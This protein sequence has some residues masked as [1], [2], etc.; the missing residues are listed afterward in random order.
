MTY[1]VPVGKSRHFL[2]HANRLIDAVLGGYNFYWTYTIASGVPA[3]MSISGQSLPTYTAGT[4]TFTNINVPQY[5]SFMPNFGGLILLKRPSLRDN[6]QDLGGDRFNH[7]NQNSMIN[8]GAA[9]VNWGNDCFTYT[10]PFSLGNNGANLWNNQRI[11][12]AS[13]ALAKEVPLKGEPVPSGPPPG[14]P[15]PLQVV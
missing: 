1:Q 6:W 4:S 8:C 14:L 7:V 2:S 3:G 13:A 11:I 15:E 5:P 12:A 10:P 9:V